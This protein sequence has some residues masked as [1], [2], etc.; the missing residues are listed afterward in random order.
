MITK[1]QASLATLLYADIFDYPLT[2]SEFILWSIKRS[3]SVPKEGE[4]QGNFIFLPKRKHLIEAREDREQF[5][6]EKW[7]IAQKAANVL[8]LI[9]TIQLIGVTG[10]LSMNNAKNEDD[11]DFFFIT[12]VGCLWI[13]RLF[14]VLIMEVLGKRRRRGET[15]VKN[16]I[17]LNMFMTQQNLAVPEAEHDLY[18]AH[19]VLQMKP[20]W[21]RGAAYQKFLSANSWTQRFLPNAWKERTQNTEHNDQHGKI[22]LSSGI[23][24]LRFLEPLARL[25]QLHYMEKH[26]T[27]EVIGDSVVR[28]HPKDARVWVKRALRIR[29]KRY[30]IP[31]DNV[32]YDR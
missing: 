31:L 10:G 28:F 32:F 1:R 18:T 26:R 8:R 14:A 6:F 30:D 2:K 20:M 17:C 4:K 22:L 27:T 23:W 19:E 16:S 29:L 13:T 7:N 5:A 25:V 9:P 15:N 12:S 24:V 3:V 21:A 11:I